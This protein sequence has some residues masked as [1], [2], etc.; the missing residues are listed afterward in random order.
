MNKVI[1]SGYIGTD[2]TAV[3]FDTNSNDKCSFPLATR[4]AGFVNRQGQQ[5]A[6]RTDW[7]NIVCWGGLARVCSNNLKKGSRVLVEGKLRYR[8]YTDKNNIQR[9]IAEVEAE[10]VEFLSPRP[11]Q[12]E[13]TTQQTQEQ[14]IQ[15]DWE[16]K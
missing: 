6:E 1:L 2:P 7:H 9:T 10:E 5:I 16:N 13:A 8:A 15:V 11:A 12:T 3:H 14:A 4:E